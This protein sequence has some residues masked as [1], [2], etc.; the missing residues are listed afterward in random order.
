[1]NIPLNTL[2][3]VEFEHSGIQRCTIGRCTCGWIMRGTKAEV[4]NKAAV[5]DLEQW[6]VDNGTQAPNAV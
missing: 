6:E 5:H 4:Y 1:M 3:N 2:H